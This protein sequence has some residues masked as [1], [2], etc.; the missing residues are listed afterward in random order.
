VLAEAPRI[1]ES[2][3]ALARGLAPARVLLADRVGAAVLPRQRAAPL[4]L[5]H[6]GL[7]AHG[8]MIS[9]APTR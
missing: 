1:H 5:V 8:P 4:D 2:V 9:E 7:P 6:L 3:D